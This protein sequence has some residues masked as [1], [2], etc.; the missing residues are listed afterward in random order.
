MFFTFCKTVNSTKQSNRHTII[1]FLF[2]L[3]VPNQLQVLEIVFIRRMLV[4]VA[5]NLATELYGILIVL[6]RVAVLEQRHFCSFYQ[7]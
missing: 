4:G 3:I 5:S 7:L 6:K 1:L 2:T